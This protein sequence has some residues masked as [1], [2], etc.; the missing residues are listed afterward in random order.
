MCNKFYGFPLKKKGN[1]LECN[2]ISFL[3]NIQGQIPSQCVYAYVYVHGIV[4]RCG[5]VCPRLESTVCISF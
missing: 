2:T 1:I 3:S 4:N 5:N